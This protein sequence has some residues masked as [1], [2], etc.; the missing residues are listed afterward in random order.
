MKQKLFGIVI[1]LCSCFLWSCQ[2][3]KTF[4]ESEISLIPQVQKM[5]LGESSF[6]FSNSTQLIVENKDQESVA[7][8]FS[9][10]FEKSAGWKP[11][12][13]VGGNVSSNQV[14]FKTETTM[15]PEAY[16]LRVFKNRI[17][18]KAAKP[19][20]FFYAMQTLRQLLP[21]QIESSQKVADVVW[22]VPV[23]T[24]SDNPVF[25]W[26]G[27]MLDVSRHFFPKVEVLRMIDHLALHKINTFHLHLT[28]DQGWRIEIKKYPKLTQVGDCVSVAGVS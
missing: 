23:V 5:V 14:Y 26:R 4:K 28:D 19:A 17:E 16:S 27:Y 12:V 22:R 9:G 7:I 25:K 24:I 8:L 10:L 11:Q 18:V 20:G 3:P 2:Q 1:L 21:V 13:T 6:Q 15:E